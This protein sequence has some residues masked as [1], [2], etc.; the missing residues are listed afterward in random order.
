M[1][2]GDVV[3]SAELNALCLGTRRELTFSSPC[4]HFPS[5]GGTG[6]APANGVKICKLFAYPDI[7][8]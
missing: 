6:R 7:F 2:L 8:L 5:G 3:E 1:C 4:E